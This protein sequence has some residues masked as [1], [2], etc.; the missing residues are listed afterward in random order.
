MT[1]AD[2]TDTEDPFL[3]V[4]EREKEGRE[5]GSCQ[6]SLGGGFPPTELHCRVTL[7]FSSTSILRLLSSRGP[8]LSSSLMR[9]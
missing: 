4:S 9:R 2:I 1:R 8:R 3:T 5:S 6:D 7:V